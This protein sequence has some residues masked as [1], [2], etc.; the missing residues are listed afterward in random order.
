MKMRRITAL[1]MLLSFTLEIITSIV[2]FIVPEGR[3]AYWSDWSMLGLS[4]TQWADI[5]I[6]LGFLFIA[7]GLLHL[8][9][10]WKPMIAYMKNKA[11]QVKIFTPDFNAA[12]IITA[13]FTVGTLLHVPPLSMILNLSESFKDAAAETYG[14][15]PYGHAERSSLKM[16][17][18]RTGLDLATMQQQLKD[19]GIAFT[20]EKQTLLD[21]ARA[22]GTSPKEIYD[23][24]KQPNPQL[25]SG[26]FPSFPDQP[27]P[28][29]GRQV[30]KDL[31]GA[32]GID[33]QQ[34]TA[35][36]KAKGI[37]GAP[38]QTLKEIAAA[39]NTDPH[40]LFEIIHEVAT[41]K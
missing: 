30:L 26:E 3:V 22:N 1:I 35:A 33:V 20:D 10:N 24:F 4:K 21:I 41:Q 37:K 19:G 36:F 8:F 39:N 18:K 28:G 13:L 25:D 16:L 12:L 9:Y 17:A 40:T 38:A 32:Y 5:H 6:N 34:V 2:L 23:H 27:F 11:R 15:P 7:A 14:E 31:L 29:L